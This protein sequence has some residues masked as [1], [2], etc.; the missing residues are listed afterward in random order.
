MTVTC[1]GYVVTGEQD[2]DGQTDPKT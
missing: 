2:G 1:P